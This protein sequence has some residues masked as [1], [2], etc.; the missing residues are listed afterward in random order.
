MK[1]TIIISGL[2]MLSVA[3]QSCSTTQVSYNY[4][5]VCQGVGSQGSNLVKV[6]S[7]ASTM[8][9]ATRQVK[10]DA[11]HGILFKG[12]LGGNRCSF[13]PPIVSPAELESHKE[14]FDNFFKGDYERFVN[15][16]SDG[17]IP[18]KDRLRVGSKYKIGVT[19]SV[20]KNELRKYLENKGV[21]KKLGH[22]F[23]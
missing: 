4:E 10:R 2:V 14:F 9:E 13:Q 20:N 22:L 19:V 6:Y 5:M 21:I 12:I 7:Y 15:L 16:S 23:E 18:A 3:F 8:E 1:K 11:V 17:N